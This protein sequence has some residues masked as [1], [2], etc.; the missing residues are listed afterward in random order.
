MATLL[1]KSV[2]A[3]FLLVFGSVLLFDVGCYFVLP[4]DF[5]RIFLG[6]RVGLLPDGT[7]G[8]GY[9]HNY[10]EAHTERGFDIG[11]NKEPR[12][13]HVF[14][15]PTNYSYPIWSNS[16]GCFDHE[17]HALSRYIYLAG[18]STSWGYTR[19]EKKIGSLLEQDLGVP[20]LK[21]G[22]T[23]SGQFH[24]LSKM[25]GVIEKVK[26][27][28]SLIVV[29]WSSNDVVND[30]FYPH[31]TEVNGWLV[32]TVYTGSDGLAQRGSR[33]DAQEHVLKQELVLRSQ[34][35]AARWFLVK[36]SATY[37][38]LIHAL[39]RTSWGQW[40]SRGMYDA[41]HRGSIYGL[42]QVANRT[43]VFPYIHDPLAKK[44]QEALMRMQ[45]YASS[46]G[47]PLVVVLLSLHPNHNVE[48]RE[49]LR[50]KGIRFLDL[51]VSDFSFDDRELTWRIDPHPNESGNAVIAR[52]VA[53]YIRQSKLLGDASGSPERSTQTDP[54]DLS[55][56]R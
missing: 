46:I 19:F 29:V 13:H 27:P 17:H 53:T 28:P 2:V 35:K 30:A 5:S 11:V 26:A 14:H 40:L 38:V 9:P 52:A 10:Y 24:Q 1:K 45:E 55:I 33:D 12:H 41:P 37:N 3:I 43:P 47:A 8:H 25:K 6:Y 15:Y 54:P 51:G 23:H 21:C 42:Q 4:E 31:S 36:Y 48:V 44:N 49:F 34:F 50:G 20:V 7:F 39:I 18:D 22:V 32:D 16:L 56:L